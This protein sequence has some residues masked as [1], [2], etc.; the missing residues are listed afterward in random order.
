MSW[1][2]RPVGDSTDELE[3][4]TRLV[5][6]VYKSINQDR[7]LQCLIRPG[8][9]LHVI[10]TKHP[11]QIR[12]LAPT[13]GIIDDRISYI[14]SFDWIFWVNSDTDWKQIWSSLNSCYSV[15]QCSSPVK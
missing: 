15:R 14:Y 11:N 2:L 4:F 9:P 6:N 10:I 1:L 8:Y 13:S 7:F 5:V 12:S 3:D